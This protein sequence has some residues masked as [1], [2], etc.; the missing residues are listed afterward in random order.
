MATENTESEPALKL[1]NYRP[2]DENID[3]AEVAPADVLMVDDHVKDLEEDAQAQGKSID[4]NKFRHNK[5]ID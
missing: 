1:R 4:S 5:L 3:R 2:L